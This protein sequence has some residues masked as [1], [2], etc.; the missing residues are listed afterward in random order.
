[1]QKLLFFDHRELEAARGFTRRLGRPTRCRANPLLV[2]DQPWENGNLQLYGSVCRAS[3][4]IFRL[5]YSTVDDPWCIRLAYAESDDGLAWR[6]PALDLHPYRR[7]RTNLVLTDDVHGAAVICDEQDPDPERRFKLAAGLRPSGCIAVL[8]SADGIH[9][10]R[11]SREPQLPFEPDCPMAFFRAPDGRYVVLH[12]HRRL[13]RR[14]CRSESWD[15]EHWTSEPRMILE[16]GPADAPQTQLY[17][18]G[19]VPYGPYELGS[20]WIFHTDEEEL[21]RGHMNGYQDAELTYS[22]SGFAWHRAAPGTPFIAHGG[23][24]A[25]DRGNLQ[26]ASQPVF[27]DDEIRYYYAGTDMRHQRHWELEPQRA[28]L[29]MARLRPDGFVALEAGT[30]AAE[31]M[32]VAFVPQGGELFV[33]ADVGK[34]G[35]VKVGVLDDQARPLKDRGVDGCGPLTGDHTGHRVRWRAAADLP[36]DRPVRL[37]VRARQ[38]SLY[39]VYALA[40]GEEPVYHRFQALW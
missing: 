18:M 11:L 23:G 7:R 21:G 3:D 35:W 33:N 36:T 34:G 40:A 20:L 16:P 28:G 27:L 10:R 4:G 25:W 15:L 14:V 24:R 37:C 2:A 9:W 5:W 38:A 22:R 1:M 30:R 19:V 17:G 6:R 8:V 39:S 29:G 13:G 26:C 31:L 12:R 32:T